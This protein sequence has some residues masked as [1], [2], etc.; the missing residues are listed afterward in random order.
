M[1][2]PRSDLFLFCHQCMCVCVCL[3]LSDVSRFTFSY[4]IINLVAVI[5]NIR[6]ITIINILS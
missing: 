3:L 5:N 6:V 1:F 2:F 4:N